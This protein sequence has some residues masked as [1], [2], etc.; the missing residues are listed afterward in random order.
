M[1]DPLAPI[2]PGSASSP[3]LFKEEMEEERI[4]R[5]QKPVLEAP[6]P[7]FQKRMIEMSDVVFEL[8]SKLRETREKTLQEIT[9]ELKAKNAEKYQKLKESAENAQ[10]EDSWTFFENMVGCVASSISIAL[11]VAMVASGVGTILGGVMIAAG[12]VGIANVV[13][14]ETGA[15]KALAE[16]IFPDDKEKQ[17]LLQWFLPGAVALID[18]GLSLVGFGLSFFGFAGQLAVIA[19]NI[20]N[21]IIQVASGI[22]AAEKGITRAKGHYLQAETAVI[23]KELYLLQEDVK[24]TTSDMK[25]TEKKLDVHTKAARNMKEFNQATLKILSLKV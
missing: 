21:T 23:E 16:K 14:S 20:G 19:T 12:V 2:M 5:L 6:L 25:D 8:A 7:S 24:K 17:Q 9:D 3:L 18:T 22:A 4:V 13:L 10:L 15:Y 11:G 1:P